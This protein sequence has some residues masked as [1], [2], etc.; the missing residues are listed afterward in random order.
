MIRINVFY[1]NAP[2]LYPLEMSENLWFSAVSMGG[3]EMNYS[4]NNI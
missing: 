1:I 3:I 4:A 2:F